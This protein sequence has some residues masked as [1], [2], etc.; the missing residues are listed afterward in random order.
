MYNDDGALAKVSES[1]QD[2]L[3]GPLLI[4]STTLNLGLGITAMAFELASTFVTEM[5][6]FY[7]KWF[8][9]LPLP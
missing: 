8:H 2:G 6:L 5:F 9:L 4:V 7:S 3:F 1:S